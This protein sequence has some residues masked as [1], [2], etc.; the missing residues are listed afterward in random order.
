MWANQTIEARYHKQDSHAYFSIS[1]AATFLFSYILSFNE[2][3][4]DAL[5]GE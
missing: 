4:Q 1:S 5:S 3:T 2:R